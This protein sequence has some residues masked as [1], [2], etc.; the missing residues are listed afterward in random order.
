MNTP[1]SHQSHQ[2][3]YTGHVRRKIWAILAA[4]L[5]LALAVPLGTLWHATLIPLRAQACVWPT[6]PR[7]GSTAYLVVALPDPTDR[8]A[9][10]GPWAQVSVSWDMPAMAMDKHPVVAHGSPN[11]AS[12]TAS[13]AIPLRLDMAG[14]WWIRVTLRTPGRPAWQSAMQVAVLPP[15]SGIA[16][17]LETQAPLQVFTGPAL[18][19]SNAQLHGASALSEVKVG[20]MWLGPPEE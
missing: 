20:H 2:E 6:V 14:P 16:P 3:A 12:D 4:T 1:M 5:V 19:A 11:R 18:C 10:A 8:T 15:L 9:V 13:F 17:P 7:A